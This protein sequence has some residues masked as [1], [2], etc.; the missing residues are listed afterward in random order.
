MKE[1]HA[2]L[3]AWMG[4]GV[5]HTPLLTSQSR[6]LSIGKCKSSDVPCMLVRMKQKLHD[7]LIFKCSSS[8][9]QHKVYIGS[10]SIKCIP[11][12]NNLSRFGYYHIPT[13]LTLK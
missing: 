12:Y 11:K 6:G 8:N 13:G 5:N 1:N 2:S 3:L 4:S 7:I 9:L 10:K